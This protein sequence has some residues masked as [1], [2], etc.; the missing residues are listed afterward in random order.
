MW[1]FWGGSV[2]SFRLRQSV[3][4]W[5]SVSPLPQAEGNEP[6]STLHLLH[7]CPHRLRHYSAT[8]QVS[9]WFLCLH[10]FCCTSV[11]CCYIFEFPL[12]NWTFSDHNKITCFSPLSCFI[13]VVMVIQ[14]ICM[15]FSKSLKFKKVSVIFIM[16]LGRKS[17][18]CWNILVYF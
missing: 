10:L 4:P 13:S 11:E 3:R 9:Y 16:K 5:W 14:L 15:T 2:Q 18:N 12:S 8:E 17:R 7:S 1:P 6:T